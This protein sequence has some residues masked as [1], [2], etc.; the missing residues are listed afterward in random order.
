MDTVKL[1]P[2]RQNR[3]RNS[4]R[5][6]V[7]SLEISRKGKRKPPKI[8]TIREY[9]EPDERFYL[10]IVGGRAYQNEPPRKCACREMQEELDTL[11][12]DYDTPLLEDHTHHGEDHNTDVFLIGLSNSFK[13]D[14]PNDHWLS[15][16][17]V[18][19]LG[20]EFLGPHDTPIQ[21]KHLSY[22]RK[23]FAE[24]EEVIGK[25]HSLISPDGG[26]PE[27]FGVRER[28]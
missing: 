18:L 6:I 17:E 27:N 24:W 3:G 12:S 25:L 4:S 16:S 2:R 11:Q 14:I 5:V 13:L 15:L 19:M 26:L 23:T 28:A 20:S 21:P 10:R 22:V 9:F 7:T 1:L 8:L